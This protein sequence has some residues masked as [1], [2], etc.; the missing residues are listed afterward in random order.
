[1]HYA[2]AFDKVDHQL[3]LHKL[4]AYGIRG[5]LLSW[6]KAYLSDR[7][8]TVVINGKPS[9][10]AKVV[11][12]VPQGTVLGPILFLIYLNDLNKCLK[13]SVTSSFADDTRIKKT[14]NNTIDTQI[15]QED[16]NKAVNWSEKS[17]MVLH[18][19]KF[20]LLI[21]RADRSHHLDQLPFYPEFTHY[22]TNDGSIISPSN[23]VKDLGVT[24]SD[25]LT[26]SK[27]ISNTTD[28]ARKISSWVFS[29]FSN[30]TAKITIPLYKALVRSRAEYNCP[31]WNPSK[32]E[33]IKSIESI[34][35]SFTSKIQEVQHLSYWERLKSLNIMSLQRRRERYI[36]IHVYKIIKNLAPNEIGMTFYQNQRK[37]LMCKIPPITKNAKIKF[38]KLYD[39]SFH[40]SGAKLWNKLPKDVKEKRTLD[41][42]KNALTKFIMSFPDNP[43]IHGTSSRNSLLEIPMINTYNGG[44]DSSDED[45]S[46]MA[47]RLAS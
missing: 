37:G 13:H 23:H 12:G 34:Q 33:D 11:S 1:M 9:S 42:F 15:L 28:A 46:R 27:H 18:Q 31:V 41:S 5:K 10:S 35:R 25:D 24:I 43:P 20:E 14:I 19:D 44:V 32:I 17:N 45:G 16:L 7:T 40:V 29:V 47:G 3:L 6:L 39:S 38:Q 8:Q 4:H 30:R 21:H 36:I 22:T 26:W 2:K